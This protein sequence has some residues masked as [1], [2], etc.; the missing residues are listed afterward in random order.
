M[1]RLRRRN[2]ALSTAAALI[3]VRWKRRSSSRTSRPVRPADELDK[4]EAEALGR[5][6]H[7]HAQLAKH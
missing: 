2:H 5:M 7:L 6:R 4:A 1:A 3:V